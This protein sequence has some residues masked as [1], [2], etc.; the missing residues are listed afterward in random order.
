MEEKIYD[1][2]VTKQSLSLRVVDEKQAGRH[3][4]AS[5][6]AE[7]FTYSPAPPPPEPGCPTTTTPERPQVN[8]H[9]SFTPAFDSP[10]SYHTHFFLQVDI[11]LCT[12]LD[13]LQPTWIVQYHEHNSLLEHIFDEELS[14]ADQKAA[15][16]SYNAD[17]VA[18]TAHYNFQALHS[19][20]EQSTSV[21]VASSSQLPPPATLTHG[22]NVS[23]TLFSYL[24]KA[25]HD[26]DTLIMKQGH[27]VRLAQH[28]AQQVPPIQSVELMAVNQE[29]GQLYHDISVS[30][31]DSNAA[32]EAFNQQPVSTHPQVNQKVVELRRNLLQKI[33]WLRQMGAVQPVAAPSTRPDSRRLGQ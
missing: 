26:V 21:T 4:T 25:I 5:D 14:E 20:L 6:L 13:K 16:E 12:I 29:I 3:F 17:K 24:T 28:V 1:R 15:W 23:N 32:L 2:Q 22:V 18:E 10:I 7:L 9:T 19:R 11:T 27:K 31:R 8:T 30:I 33:D